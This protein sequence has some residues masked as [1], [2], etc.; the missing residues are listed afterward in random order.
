VATGSMPV[1]VAAVAVG[2]VWMIAVSCWSS[3]MTAVFQL[4]LYRYATQAPLPSEFAQVN[5]AEAFGHKKAG[6]SRFGLGG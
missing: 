4:A 1:I 2:V 6:A 5:L 3:A